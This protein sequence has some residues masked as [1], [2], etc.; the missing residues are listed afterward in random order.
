[1]FRS[2][3]A[4]GMSVP[5]Y[6]HQEAIASACNLHMSPGRLTLHEGWCFIV[7]TSVSRELFDVLETAEPGLLSPESRGMIS[8]WNGG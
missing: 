8:L 3:E 5:M 7:L 6:V 1:M 2:T 4:K